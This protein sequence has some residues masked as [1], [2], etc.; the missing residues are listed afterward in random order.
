[1]LLSLMPL[2]SPGAKPPVP[3][4]PLPPLQTGKSRRTPTGLAATPASP[5][6]VGPS[7]LLAATYFPLQIP[8]GQAATSPA[9]GS[10]EALLALDQ[11]APSTAHHENASRDSTTVLVL[12]IELVPYIEVD[13][14]CVLLRQSQFDRC[15]VHSGQW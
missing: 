7:F 15:L 3:R 2:C 9:A 8:H 11:V 1:M 13:C 4:P 12:L 6:A 5:M 10:P 14:E